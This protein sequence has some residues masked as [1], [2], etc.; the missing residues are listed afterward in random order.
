M[1]NVQAAD[2][3]KLRTI[4]YIDGFNFYYGCLKGTNYKW[5]NPLLLCQNMLNDTHDFIGLKYFSA[6]VSNTPDDLS[7]ATRQQIYYRA[8]NSLPST[9]IILGHFSTHNTN[10]RLVK[11]IEYEVQHPFNGRT[12]PVKK[13]VVE[14]IK[15]EEK[16]SDVN[17]ASEML[18]DGFNNSFEVAILISNDSDLEKPVKHL[19]SVLHKKVIVLNP[20]EIKSIQ[21][22]K[23]S[24]FSKN[25]TQDHLKIS[26]FTDELKDVKG[27]FRKPSGW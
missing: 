25:I 27:L 6:K 15:Y 14:V 5:V 12:V 8:L 1:T 16:G 24:T 2:L 4:I 13:E 9:Q 17:L 18:I 20:H 3:V 22:A 7:K 26:L 21:L 19:K 10:M 23:W 11:P